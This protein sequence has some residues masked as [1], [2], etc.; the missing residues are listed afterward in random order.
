MAILKNYISTK[1]PDFY[2]LREILKIIMLDPKTCS[3]IDV[4]A[5]N[6]LLAI[7]CILVNS[8]ESPDQDWYSVSEHLLTCVYR[9]SP[10]P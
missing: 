8:Q 1:R 10:N 9:I 3:I 5:R 6:L 4:N 7:I 2:I